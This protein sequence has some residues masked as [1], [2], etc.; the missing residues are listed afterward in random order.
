MDIEDK[1]TN[2][3]MIVFGLFVSGIIPII[4][5]LDFIAWRYFFQQIGVI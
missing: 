1:V 2:I 3:M 5:M 4:C